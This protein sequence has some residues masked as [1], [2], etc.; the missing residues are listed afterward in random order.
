MWL[1]LKHVDRLSASSLATLESLLHSRDD[2]WKTGGR[3]ISGVTSNSRTSIPLHAESLSPIFLTVTN[4]PKPS[5][6]LSQVSTV[7][8][9]LAM[10]NRIDICCMQLRT[11]PVTG[12][13]WCVCILR[14]ASY[15]SSQCFPRVPW[16]PALRSFACA[17]MAQSAPKSLPG[18]F[19]G[20]CSRQCPV[21][22]LLARQLHPH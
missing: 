21:W 6:L 18:S 1:L 16:T 22:R 19:V 5:P 7:A 12:C 2:A 17:D 3:E 4:C 9:L 15:P 10:C 13:V 11:H 14:R 8:R 20:S